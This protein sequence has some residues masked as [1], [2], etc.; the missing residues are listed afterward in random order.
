MSNSTVL[1]LQFLVV[2]LAVVLIILAVEQIVIRMRNAT[3]LRYRFGGLKIVQRVKDKAQAQSIANGLSL[4]TFKNIE[5]VDCIG[6]V[7]HVMSKSGRMV[8]INEAKTNG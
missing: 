2:M 6:R 4:H 3:Y 5:I 8:R 1:M 7:T